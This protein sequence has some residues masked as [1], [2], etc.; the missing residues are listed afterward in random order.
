MCKGWDTGWVSGVQLRERKI[1]EKEQT[2][3]SGCDRLSHYVTQ[4]SRQEVMG[5]QEENLGQTKKSGHSHNMDGVESQGL[6]ET[7]SGDRSPGQCLRARQYEV[8][9]KRTKCKG[10]RRGAQQWRGPSKKMCCP[11]CQVTQSFLK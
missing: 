6:D 4:V 9:E 2:L 8:R 5:I 7:A 11:G 10:E 1:E 3:R